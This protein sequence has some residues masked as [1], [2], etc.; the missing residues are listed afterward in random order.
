M[1]KEAQEEHTS[2]RK[3]S[4][5]AATPVE[6]ADRDNLQAEKPRSQEDQADQ[7][8]PAKA[9]PKSSHELP[10][11]RAETIVAPV[12]GLLDPVLIPRLSGVATSQ[13][14]RV[15]VHSNIRLNAVQPVQA[16][17]VLAEPAF[18]T[19][20]LPGQVPLATSHQSRFQVLNSLHAET[21][22][23]KPLP[24]KSETASPGQA[25]TSQPIAAIKYQ[26]E[27]LPLVSTLADYNENRIQLH[28]Q[29][30]LEGPN[31]KD[32]V[33]IDTT[34]VTVVETPIAAVPIVAKE[35]T[36]PFVASVPSQ[37][38]TQISGPTVYLATS[39]VHPIANWPI[40]TA[41]IAQSSQYRSQVHSS[42]KIEVTK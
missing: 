6:A 1:A 7:P 2:R 11:Q 39:Y 36:L 31:R 26:L 16:I 34:P 25:A 10:E 37:T 22:P 38:R 3:R 9:S 42:E 27:A 29:L 17:G 12:Y 13:Q 14:S 23:G 40:L 28:K 35:T 19:V 21:S 15:D 20:I 18:G 30:G 5:E 24:G 32:A 8:Q 4:A 33:K 41:P